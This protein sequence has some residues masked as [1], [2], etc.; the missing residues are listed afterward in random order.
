MGKDEENIKKAVEGEADSEK[1]SKTKKPVKNED[2]EKDEDIEKEPKL[3]DLPG[4]GPA[5]ATKLDSAGIFDLMGLAVM[6]PSD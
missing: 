2:T 6:S 4:I 3:T 1:V 5:V